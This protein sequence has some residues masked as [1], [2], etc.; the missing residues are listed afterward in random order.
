MMEP[1]AESSAIIGKPKEE[2][3][4]YEKEYPT[5]SAIT[6]PTEVLFSQ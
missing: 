1:I 6:K 3:S 5:L 2:K 4:A